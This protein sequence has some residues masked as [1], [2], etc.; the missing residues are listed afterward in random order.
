MGEVKEEDFP[1]P[2]LVFPVQASTSCYWRKCIFCDCSASEQGYTIKTVP[3]LVDE[4]EFLKKKYKTKYF[5]FWDNALHPNYLNKLADELQKRKINIIFS[6]YAR[7]EPEF[8]LQLLKKLRKAGK[9]FSPTCSG[10]LML[11][12]RS[13]FSNRII[14]MSS[15]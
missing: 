9:I 12:V 8:N 2:E 5:Y 15:R 3:R 11:T 1:L 13:I 6:I 14:S 7:F 4:I 10:R